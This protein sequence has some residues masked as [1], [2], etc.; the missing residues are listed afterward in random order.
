MG[1]VWMMQDVC[2]LLSTQEGLLE[3]LERRVGRAHAHHRLQMESDY[4]SRFD[5]R[6]NFSHPDKWYSA[7]SAMTQALKLTGMYWLGARNAERPQV[8]HNHVALR[9]LPPAFDG[10]TILHLSD[11]HVEMN[12]GAC[13]A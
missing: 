7:V 6:I 13:S 11:L 12:E 5:G 9:E 10:F 3:T 1:A 2:E 8:R 4:E